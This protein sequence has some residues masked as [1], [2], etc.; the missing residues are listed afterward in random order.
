MTSLNDDAEKPEA[1]SEPETM[2]IEE[3]FRLLDDMAGQLESDAVS[4]EESFLLYEK[5]MRLLKTLNDRI[6][7]VE[8]KMQQIDDEGQIGDFE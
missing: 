5:G 1:G 4:L 6:D 7:R 2:T 3:A 8:K